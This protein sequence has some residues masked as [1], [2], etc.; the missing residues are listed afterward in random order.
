MSFL[1]PPAHLAAK[2]PSNWAPQSGPLI[3]ESHELSAA[4]V[5]MTSTA[6]SALPMPP[7]ALS[8]SCSILAGGPKEV[9]L[10]DPLEG[11][12]N[13]KMAGVT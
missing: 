8:H 2:T 11:S 3:S 7:P 6:T 12:Q 1:V 9:A 4:R 5:S 10:R 13:S